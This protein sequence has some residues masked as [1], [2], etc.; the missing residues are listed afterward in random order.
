M[1]LLLFCE[2]FR[3][4]MGFVMLCHRKTNWDSSPV[5]LL[6]TMSVTFLLLSGNTAGVF[7]IDNATGVIFIA[8]DL[9]LSSVGFYTLTV[10]VTDSGFP[11][12]MATASARISLILSDFSQPKFSL[13]DSI[14][15][16][17]ITVNALS[18]SAVIYEISRGNDEN[19][20]F[21]NHHTGVIT[22]R[23]PLDFEQTTSYFLVVHALSMA[24]VE[25]STTV[26]VQVG[27]V[28][29]N[30]PVF[31]EIRYVGV[32]SEA[33]LVNTVVL[34][35]DG[36]PLVIQATDRD[37]N[38]NALLVFQIIDDTA[39]MFFSVDSGTGSIRTISSLDY[40]NFSE[41]V[42]RVHVRDSG[43]PPLSA[44]S[45]AEVIIKVININDSPPKLSQ[46]TY[47]AVLLRPT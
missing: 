14:G 6:V 33:A 22:T 3:P 1:Y 45:P 9:G 36:N 12:L 41:F 28:N 11:P 5:Y 44:E 30:P 10:R 21:I 13:N 19:G 34:G 35:E 39:R 15:T 38:H 46:D 32:I 8:R 40:E 23:R 7:G 29:D 18:R 2:V 20:F 17:V 31:R 4:V 37:R 26:I 27:D 43:F 24:G 42:F 47:E 25:A 16:H